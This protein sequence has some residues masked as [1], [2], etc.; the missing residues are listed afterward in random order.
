MLH[1]SNVYYMCPIHVLQMNQLH[2]LNTKKHVFNLTC[3]LHMICGTV[4][5][6]CY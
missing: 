1:M 5:E 3:L 2:V 6:T 4:P